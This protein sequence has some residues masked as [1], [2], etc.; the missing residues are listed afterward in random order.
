MTERK[1]TCK[2]MLRSA[3]EAMGEGCVR[4]SDDQII[5]LN[6]QTD[7]GI[8]KIQVDLKTYNILGAK[9]ADGDN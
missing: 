7:W 4:V 6:L 1:W 2:E 8:I 5:W 3:V 9:W